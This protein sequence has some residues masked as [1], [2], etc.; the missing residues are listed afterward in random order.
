MPAGKTLVVSCTAPIR[1]SSVTS[2]ALIA[3]LQSALARGS[4]RLDVNKTIEGNRIRARLIER[5]PAH[6]DTVIGF[7]HNRDVDAEELLLP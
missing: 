4:A 7:I 2:A 5:S 3:L 1:K 6:L